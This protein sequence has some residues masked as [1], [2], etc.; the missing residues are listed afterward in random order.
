MNILR[1]VLLAV[2]LTALVSCATTVERE[3]PNLRTQEGFEKLLRQLKEGSHARRREAM[4]ALQ[5]DMDFFLPRIIE[6]LEDT[7]V[8]G[9]LTCPIVNRAG[10]TLSNV[11]IP[12]KQFNIGAVLERFLIGYFFKDPARVTFNVHDREGATEVWK[13]W[14]TERAGAM[15]WDSWGLYSNK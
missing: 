4:L 5:F 6:H 15:R 8:S 2:I 12:A 13:K 1:T 7:D 3:P 9:G 11:T 10:R 14:Y